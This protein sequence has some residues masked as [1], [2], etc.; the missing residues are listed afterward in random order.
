MSCTGCSNQL[1]TL[2]LFSYPPLPLSSSPPLPLSSSPPLPLSSSPTLLS[3]SVTVSLTVCLCLMV[4]VRKSRSTPGGPC[5]SRRQSDS[6][7]CVSPE[8]PCHF[9]HGRPLQLLPI[10]RQVKELPT[11]ERAVR[12]GEQNN[13]LAKLEASLVTLWPAVQVSRCYILHRC[14]SVNAQVITVNETSPK[15]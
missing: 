6:L 14:H 5:H 9:P 2:F 4:S 11:G 7:T 1:P 12:F 10:Q 8:A 3:H 15:S 13:S